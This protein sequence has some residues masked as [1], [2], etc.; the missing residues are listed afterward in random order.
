MSRRSK[1]GGCRP[2][3][4]LGEG[5]L[6]VMSGPEGLELDAHVGWLG[7]GSWGTGAPRAKEAGR[8]PSEKMQT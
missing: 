7:Q 6:T 8:S 2:G 1:G 4:R 3:S 5:C